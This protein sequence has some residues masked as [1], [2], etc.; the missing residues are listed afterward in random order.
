MIG[1]VVART[2]PAREFKL[3]KDCREISIETRIPVSLWYKSKSRHSP[4]RRPLAQLIAPRLVFAQAGYRKI[5]Q[6]KGLYYCEGLVLDDGER[7]PYVIPHERMMRFL[8]AVDHANQ[9][10]SSAEM[11]AREAEAEVKKAVWH[12]LGGPGI[13]SK[14]KSLVGMGED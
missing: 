5:E 10:I 4:V 2:G 6:L 7:R 12:K 14:L 3:A 13:L 1:W 11:A 9:L 8:D